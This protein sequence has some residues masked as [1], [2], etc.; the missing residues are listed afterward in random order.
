MKYLIASFLLSA[1][2]AW[3]ADPCPTCPTETIIDDVSGGLATAI[4]KH[5]LDKSFSPNLSNVIIDEDEIKQIK[6]FVEVGST[7]TL[8]RVDGIYPYNLEDGSVFF[9]VTGASMVLETADFNTY[10]FISSGQNDSV[11]TRCKQIQSKMWCSNGVD[12]VFTWNHTSKVILDG[13]NGTP[14][15][16]KGKFIENYHERV[17]MFNTPSNASSVYFSDVRSTN[18]VII[19]PDNFLA[20]PADNLLFAGRGDGQVGTAIWVENGQ[21]K[22]GKERSIYTMFGT[23]PSNYLPRLSN[24]NIG[25]AS[26]DS[27]VILDNEINFVGNDGIYRG[28]RRNSDLIK[29]ESESIVRTGVR[30]VSNLWESEGDFLKGQFSGTT[31]TVSGLLT[32]NTKSTE[33]YATKTFYGESGSIV[34]NAGTTSQTLHLSFDNAV[35]SGSLVYTSQF[36]SKCSGGGNMLFSIINLNSGE[37]FDAEKGCNGSINFISISSPLF[38]AYEIYGGSYVFKA[39]LYSG[40]DISMNVK[41]VASDQD[42]SFTFTPT[43]TG[44]YISDVATNTSITNWGN[45]DSINNT[46]GGKISYYIRTSTS[47][48][49]I[50]TQTWK[51]ISP[52]VRIGVPISNRFIQWASTIAS[53]SSFTNV[54]NIDN[55]Q[56]VHIEGEGSLNR[57]FGISWKNR[58]WIWVSTSANTISSYG[59][60][61]SKITNKN[62]DAW[63]P[64]SGINI[65]SFGKDGESTL[66]GGS[67]SSGTVYRLDFGDTF[68]GNAIISFYET[69]N[70]Y[71]DSLYKEKS[72]YEYFVT[73]DENPGSSFTLGISVDDGDFTDTSVSLNGSGLLN[74][75]ISNVRAKG[76]YFRWRFSHNTYDD[77]F[78]LH[79]FAVRYQPTD[80]RKGIND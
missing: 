10:V 4:P 22:L 42:Q 73:A 3:G 41:N 77:G 5:K 75:S 26:N 1:S 67:S 63:M 39:E 25:V 58:P 20:W 54:S 28:E 70:V 52:G 68:N 44:Q 50:T 2:L 71:F 12:D 6:G 78:K 31:V 11:L 35:T 62:P 46:N 64:V 19:T 33:T 74:R 34:L 23:L 53:I 66:Y 48:V 18:G 45:F 60:M 43:T 27:V 8:E 72:L 40:V 38:T 55:V 76:K 47:V 29:D 30:T 7:N 15:V 13:T 65:R 24:Q 49:N 69:P 51:P 14:N 9:I 21:L 17:W 37:R 59:L 16:P 61:R 56:I 36:R 57:P 80:A 79:N 32:I